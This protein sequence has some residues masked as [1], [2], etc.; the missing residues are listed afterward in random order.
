MA[1]E[2]FD[3]EM[4]N[5][6]D[7]NPL[8]DDEYG[9]DIDVANEH[10]DH[11]LPSPE[12]RGVKYPN[13]VVQLVGEDGNAWAILGR[14]SKAMRRGGVPQAEIDAFMKEA[15]A[16]DYDHLLRTCMDYVVVE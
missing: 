1:N 10:E 11:S 9:V 7:D 15:M 14:V 4:D 12:D 13:I 2:S 8:E 3:E 16:G 5:Q 6:S